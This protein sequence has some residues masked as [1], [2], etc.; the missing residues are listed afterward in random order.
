MEEIC[1]IGYPL[2]L[3]GADTELDHQIRVWQARRGVV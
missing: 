2:R 1:V 3:G